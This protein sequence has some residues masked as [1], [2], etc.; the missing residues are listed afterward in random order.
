MNNLVNNKE[1][2]ESITKWNF[3]NKDTTPILF[4]IPKDNGV[5]R[6]LK[7]SNLY[8]YCS[9]IKVVMENRLEIINKLTEDKESTSRFFGYAPYTY[10]VSKSIENNILNSCEQKNK[11]DFKTK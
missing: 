8:S 5:R 2:F 9:T 4:T 10:S 6:P 1:L 11:G 7:F 3:K